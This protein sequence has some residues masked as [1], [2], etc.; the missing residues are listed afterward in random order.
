MPV[1]VVTYRGEEKKFT[2]EE[3]SSMILMKMKN[4][5]EAFLGS[6]VTNVVVTVP[7]Y[8]NNS[9]RQATK[10]QGS[11][12]HKKDI[13]N[14]NRALAKLKAASERAKRILSMNFQT[15]VEVDSLFDNIDFTSTITRARFE[16]LN[17][18]LLKKC[19]DTVKVLRRCQDR[20]GRKMV[21]SKSVS[22]ESEN[23]PKIFSIS[24]GSI[25]TFDDILQFKGIHYVVDK[26]RKLYIMSFTAFGKLEI[27]I[28]E[29][30]GHTFDLQKYRLMLLIKEFGELKDITKALDEQD[31]MHKKFEETSTMLK[32][33]LAPTDCIYYIL[34]LKLTFEVYVLE[35]E[36]RSYQEMVGVP[37]KQ[38]SEDNQQLTWFKNKSALY[39]R[40]KKANEELNNV[41]SEKLRIKMDKIGSIIADI[42]SAENSFSWPL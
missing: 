5:S 8:F 6:T 3:I 24:Y 38:M 34:S 16:N 4:I 14:N 17:M 35:Y 39:Q 12:K 32:E 7:A 40:Q 10:L 22:Q 33:R 21:G 13:S 26:L 23:E 37:L 27:I 31:F 29:L 11:M 30:S 2:P 19:L 25:D 36:I 15:I 20:K 1:F 42:S 28:N 9:Q 41:L 18:D